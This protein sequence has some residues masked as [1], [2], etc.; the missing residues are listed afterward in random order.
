MLSVKRLLNCLR[1]SPFTL[2]LNQCSFGLIENRLKNKL[3][4]C[5]PTLI[6]W[7]FW[8]RCWDR[9]S[10]RKPH[11]HEC[12]I[13]NLLNGV[14]ATLTHRVIIRYMINITLTGHIHRRIRFFLVNPGSTI[15]L[16]LIELRICT[17]RI[18]VK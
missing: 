18:M 4:C 6:L 10:H 15:T 5:L 3:P 11:S 1:L 16:N 12:L 13:S 2:F 8:Y 7:D 9:P 17:R 14:S